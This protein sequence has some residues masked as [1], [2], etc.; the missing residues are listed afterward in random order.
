MQAR[1]PL[2]YLVG[3]VAMLFT[4]LSYTSISEVFPVAG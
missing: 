3:V 2:V 4:G 1:V